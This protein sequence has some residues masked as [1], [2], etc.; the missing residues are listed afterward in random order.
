[1]NQWACQFVLHS[2]P[3]MSRHCATHLLPPGTPFYYSCRKYNQ[4]QSFPE[5]FCK[6]VGF[7]LTAAKIWLKRCTS[8]FSFEQLAS[9]WLSC[10]LNLN[11]CSS[12]LKFLCFFRY[13]CCW[14]HLRIFSSLI[15]FRSVFRLSLAADYLRH[16]FELING[17]TFDSIG[18][19]CRSS[20]LISV[21]E[22]IPGLIV[23][24]GELRSDGDEPGSVVLGVVVLGGDVPGL[25]V[26]EVS[27]GDCACFEETQRYG[28]ILSGD[29]SLIPGW[30]EAA[31]KPEG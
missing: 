11:L 20:G 17:V 9:F 15:N 21:L 30:D 31:P 12:L 27:S 25:L 22:P 3:A 8:K 2:I 6:S 5:L 7:C 19:F 4:L 16:P 23:P 13:C 18:K 26:G 14:L 24:S 28:R 10:L 1:M 29:E